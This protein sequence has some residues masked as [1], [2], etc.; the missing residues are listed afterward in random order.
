MDGADLDA[1]G[2]AQVVDG[3]FDVFSGG[4]EGDEDG[5]G[6]VGL[7]L[8]DEAV[9]AAGEFA[10]VLVGVFEEFE[11][12]LGE[13]VAP[14]DDALHVVFLVLHRAEEDGVG[15]VHHLG[16]A[17]AGGSKEDA[18]RF[19]GTVDDVFGRAEVFADQLGLVLIEGPLQVAGEEA[20]HD[21]HAG[22]ERELGDAAQDE[23][24]VGGLLRVFAEEHDP[25]GVERAIDVVV[26]AVHIEG[27][28]GERACADFE[29]HGGALAGRVV[30]LLDAVDDAL[31]G[32]E[33]DHALAADRVSNGA[34]LGRVLAFGLNGDGVVAEDVQVAL[35]IGLL[36][37]LAAFGGRGDG[38]KHAGVG[39]AGLGVVGD[40][41]ISVCGNTN[42]WITRSNR[43][44]SLSCLANLFA[45]TVRAWIRGTL[46]SNRRRQSNTSFAGRLASGPDK[47]TSKV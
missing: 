24:L 20:V 5:V 44:E 9:M 30:V 2:F 18:L 43:H 37:E 38:V 3:G 19:G 40:K 17:A 35:G 47:C 10:E 42:A 31:A 15:E 33:V 13:V 34:A 7:V 12:R 45:V 21:V 27:V 22:G 26:A 41:L 1:A 39:D 23:G 16:N 6:V 36:E 32:G 46:P 14:G 11:N 25:A 29:H 8:A 28:L 4:A